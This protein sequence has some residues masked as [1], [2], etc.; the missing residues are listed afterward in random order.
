MLQEVPIAFAMVLIVLAVLMD[1]VG[2]TGKKLLLAVAALVLLAVCYYYLLAPG[3]QPGRATRARP[4]L[5]RIAFGLL[6]LLL[7][8]AVIGFARVYTGR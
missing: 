4:G 3:W 6:A 8:G 1:H 5:R 2:V 7:I